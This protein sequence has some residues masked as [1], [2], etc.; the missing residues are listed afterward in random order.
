MPEYS[1]QVEIKKST[2]NRKELKSGTPLFNK[3]IEKIKAGD[4]TIEKLLQNFELS[5][6]DYN[7]LTKAVQK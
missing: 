5:K 3:A 6:A 4:G 7:L 1:E 2:D